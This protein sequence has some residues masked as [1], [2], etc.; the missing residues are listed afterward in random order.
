MGTG[1]IKTDANGVAYVKNIPPGKYG[2]IVVPPSGEEWY[3]TS[4]I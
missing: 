4:T 3:Q 1:I 2:V